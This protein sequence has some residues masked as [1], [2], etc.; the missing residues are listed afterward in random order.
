MFNPIDY[1][2]NL[3]KKSTKDLII[4]ILSYSW[5]LTTR[6]IYNLIKRKGLS[7]TYQAVHKSIKELLDQGIVIKQNKEYQ[8]NIEWIKKRHEFIEKLKYAYIDRKYNLLKSIE[9]NELVPHPNIKIYLGR[10]RLTKALVELVNQAQK[11]DL[12]FGQCRTCMNYPKEYFIALSNAVKRGVF[13]N[14]IVHKSLD[15]TPFVNFLHTL[16]PNQV[17]VR[18]VE[19]EYIRVLGILNKG[20]ILATPQIDSY[21]SIYFNDNRVTRY[22][23]KSYKNDWDKAPILKPK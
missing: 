10:E 9:K 7:V 19:H 2:K 23:Y 15:T 5:P 18:H 4:D 21:I 17:E 6:K 11:G 14:F 20:I 13:I 12:L 1:E 22:I 16:N 8:L 3:N